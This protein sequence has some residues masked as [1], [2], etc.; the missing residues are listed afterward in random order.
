MRGGPHSAALTHH[1][2]TITHFVLSQP[3][4]AASHQQ[5][6]TVPDRPRRARRLATTCRAGARRLA[7]TCR[8]G[9]HETGG[10]LL[11][12]AAPGAR[13]SLGF[14]QGSNNATRRRLARAIC[15]G[16]PRLAAGRG[17]DRQA[18]RA[19][20]CRRHWAKARLHAKP[21]FIGN[22][23]VT[24]LGQEPSHAA[25][26][27]ALFVLASVDWAVGCICLATCAALS[28][29]DYPKRGE[30]RR[31]GSLQ[32]ADVL[33]QCQFFAEWAAHAQWHAR[34]QVALSG[35]AGCL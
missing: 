16:S 17:E 19:D 12:G 14:G 20:R 4:L 5:L 6:A 27:F 26:C 11:V 10:R 21:D 31:C 34:A 2:N 7:T 22:C 32:Y 1:V 23:P 15:R 8:A 13:S 18:A 35:P 30:C 24:A 29:P 9:A 3:L 25:G 28:T 33:G